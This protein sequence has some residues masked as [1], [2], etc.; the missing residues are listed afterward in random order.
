MGLNSSDTWSEW[1]KWKKV[2]KTLVYALSASIAATVIAGCSGKEVPEP[3]VPEVPE[4]P[5]VPEP[6]SPEKVVYSDTSLIL[7]DHFAQLWCTGIS[8]KEIGDS[9]TFIALEA[10]NYIEGKCVITQ[11]QEDLLRTKDSVIIDVNG[12]PTYLNAQEFIDGNI[13]LSSAWQI[14]HLAYKSSANNPIQYDKKTGEISFDPNYLTEEEFKSII[15]EITAWLV[16]K[17]VKDIDETVLQNVA[18]MIFADTQTKH[19]TVPYEE[20]NSGSISSSVSFNFR[21]WT[22]NF[23]SVWKGI[24]EEKILR[25][26]KNNT[27]IIEKFWN[28]FTLKNVTFIK[29][30]SQKITG[31]IFD[32]SIWYTFARQ[33]IPEI[34][35][36]AT[37]PDIF[38]K[39]TKSVTLELSLEVPWADTTAPILTIEWSENTT[40]T[41][42]DSYTP[43][44]ATAMDDRDWDISSTIE[45]T[46]N[47]DTTTPG[48]YTVTYSI[49]DSAW[50]T[51]TKYRYVK[52]EKKEIITP[53]K[54][55]AP[56]AKA[57][58]L[59]TI[60]WE[61]AFINVL[62][63][64]SD[65]EGDSIKVVSFTQWWYGEVEEIIGG[66]FTYTPNN[67]TY[68]G[69]D[70]FNY[71]ISDWKWKTATAM[72]TV[73]I[74]EKEI[75]DETPPVITINGES[76][77]NL[78]VG[79]DYIELWAT[80]I[81]NIDWNIALIITWTVDTE[82]AWEYI[83][84]YAA[85]DKAGNATTKTRTVDVKEV[86]QN[87]AIETSWPILSGENTDNI[88][89]TNGPEVDTVVSL[90]IN[91]PYSLSTS[92]L[93]FEPI[94]WWEKVETQTVN[95]LLNEKIVGIKE[96]TVTWQ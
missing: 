28:E 45:I 86:P 91:E 44:S 76:V 20:S 39:L 74:E 2:W 83:I 47:V 26:L 87:I 7:K 68:A 4:I 25:Y 72:V 6:G 21:E 59:T 37:L 41:Q 79:Q 19:I 78:A 67:S 33:A 65:P 94:Y 11:A 58:T 31:I 61:A 81:D 82:Q 57:D 92:T 70:S 95:I 48:N 50:N 23:T 51:T 73:T 84:G 42:W 29:D 49:T 22:D 60:S 24:T 3:E 30:S 71:T 54:N 66:G 89:A 27:T 17:N 40:V 46:S 12:T 93:T 9:N 5:E 69:T 32:F 90:S 34:K 85:T 10:S 55:K 18:S 52:V 14:I 62:D 1:R 56:I 38:E 35:F 13:L 16:N 63:N 8:I 53:P 36:T 64:D 43:P 77:V 15:A 88:I 75:I 80:A 96:V